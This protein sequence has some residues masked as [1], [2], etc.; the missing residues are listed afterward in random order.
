MF[1]SSPA[2]PPYTVTELNRQIRH[3][4]EN[5]I[6]DIYVVGEVSNVS[7]PISGHIYFTLKD[8][9]AQLRCVFFRNY[10]QNKSQQVLAGE[11]LIL[12]GRLTLY[13]ARG[14]YQLMVYDLISTGVGA[15]YQQFETLKNKLEQ[16]GLFATLRK[17]PIPLYP[18]T[19][20]V[21][22]SGSGA[23]LQD[24]LSTLSRRF[25]IANVHIY[26]CEVQGKNA[27]TQ[28][29]AAI[30]QANTDKQSD[31]I[32]LARGGGS[33]EDL[34]AFNHEQLAL[35]ISQSQIPIVSGIGHETDFTIADFVADL[36]A[37]TPTAAAEAVT[38][39]QSELL[40]AIEAKI[41][42]LN[43]AIVRRIRHYQLILGHLKATLASPEQL[44]AKHWQALDY[45]YNQLGQT[46]L[47]HLTHKRFHLRLLET[48]LHAQKPQA[49]LENVKAKL[50]FINQQLQQEM[51]RRLNAFKQTL[52]QHMTNL[53]TVS[54]LATLARGY[55]IAS[56]H[57]HILFDSQ[58][59][60]VGDII[61]LTLA[62]G[63]LA[64][65][66]THKGK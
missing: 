65:Q 21:I 52:A 51:T 19:I 8:Q 1:V 11:Q 46:I 64:C 43:L 44:I 24:I 42:A 28:L 55:A 3:W 14:D 49:Y 37:A 5:E 50:Q 9:N 62:K 61:D 63:T 57:Q 58:Q 4:L 20:A 32:L 22:T 30:L 7:C 36:R 38:P 23:A 16:Q 54:P 27:P 59:V 13:E 39:L 45:L 66:V 2:P 15:L 34:W 53:D 41:A 35:T 26:P 31:V 17:K 29:I 25:P 6:N 48:T 33:I 18:L 40:S 12:R 47:R 60:N 56:H 10:Q